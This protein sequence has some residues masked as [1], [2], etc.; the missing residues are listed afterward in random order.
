MILD[1]K[2][3]PAGNKK[4]EPQGQFELFAREFLQML[5]YIIVSQPGVGADGG[6]DL[7][8]EKVFPRD[9]GKH[10]V[11]YLVSCKHYAHRGKAVGV[12]HE[13]STLERVRNHGCKGFIGFY[14]TN[15]TKALSSQL[16]KLEADF[17][18]QIFDAVIIERF[19]SHVPLEKAAVV[20]QM[21]LPASGGNWLEIHRPKAGNLP[22]NVDPQITLTFESL[23]QANMTAMI[24]LEI[25]K[26]E[27]EYIGPDWNKTEEGLAMLFRFATRNNPQ[28]AERIF[29]LLWDLSTTTRAKM[30]KSVAVQTYSLVLTFFSR[31]EGLELVDH[32]TELGIRGCDLAS[33]IVYDAI[34]YLDN[35]VVAKWGLT[36]LKF[37]YMK[38]NRSSTVPIRAAVLRS[39]KE[40]QQSLIRNDGSNYD[41]A[42][43]L[44]QH[45]KKDLKVNDL[46]WPHL[47]DDL[48][49]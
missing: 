30:P 15:A 42:K 29:E 8:V 38:R 35:L 19:F 9:A 40:L 18:L 21:F 28:I 7:I 1:F 26:I 33:N 36:I 25:D 14:S 46:S 6:Q 22:S 16:E 34:I 49:D 24:L 23:V 20:L 5:D 17:E 45:F 44:L 4:D 13:A 47:P 41:R 3:I 10:I 11:R 37:F 32:R 39:Y 27:F 48:A 2:E 43:R 31:G 12:E